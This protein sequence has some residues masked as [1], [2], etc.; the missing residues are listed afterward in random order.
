MEDTLI[1]QLADQPIEEG[2]YVCTEE[3]PWKLG[4][5]T[6]RHWMHPAAVVQGDEYGSL[7]DGGSYAHYLCPYCT[8]RFRVPLAD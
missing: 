2:R 8:L 7:S 4:H 5:G 6:D 1:N 3:Q